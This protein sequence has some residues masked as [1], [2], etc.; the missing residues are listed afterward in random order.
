MQMQVQMVKGSRRGIAKMGLEGSRR[1]GPLSTWITIFVINP[2]S[3]CAGGL[4]HWANTI[5]VVTSRRAEHSPLIA[6]AQL[7]TSC[8]PSASMLVKVA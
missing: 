7:M 5:Y 1:T 4:M 8:C 3:R 2:R 6:K